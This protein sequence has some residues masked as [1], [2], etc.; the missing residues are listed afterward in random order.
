[1]QMERLQKVVVSGLA[2]IAVGIAV[3]LA[4]IAAR[5]DEQVPGNAAGG[6][7]LTQNYQLGNAQ[8]DG[9]GQ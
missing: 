9:N 2:L 6:A 7:M 5:A 4:P 1:M 3:A 8:G